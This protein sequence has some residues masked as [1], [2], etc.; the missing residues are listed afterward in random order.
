MTTCEHFNVEEGIECNGPFR[1]LIDMG[2]MKIKTC[3]VK[4]CGALIVHWMLK[5]GHS[6]L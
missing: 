4:V 6:T 5:F 3:N 1:A 2:L